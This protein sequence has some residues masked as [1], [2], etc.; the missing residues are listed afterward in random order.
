MKN[1]LIALALALSACGPPVNSAC[2]RGAL[3]ALAGGGPGEILDVCPGLPPALRGALQDQDVDVGA[4][5]TLWD[6][7]APL[8]AALE[9]PMQALD[10]D[11]RCDLRA[12]LPATDPLAF[13]FADGAPIAGVLLSRWLERE[14]YPSEDAKSVGAAVVGGLP[15]GARPIALAG[16]P[17]S[18]EVDHTLV[19]RA[20]GALEGTELQA[21]SGEVAVLASSGAPASSLAPVLTEA[22]GRIDSL[23]LIGQSEEGLARQ[24]RVVPGP[25][26]PGIGFAG[27]IEIH[28]HPDGNLLVHG[29]PLR[30]TEAVS[31]L[32]NRVDALLAEGVPGAGVRLVPHGVSM[33][34]V[35]QAADALAHIQGLVLAPGD[36]ACGPAPAGMVCVEGASLA[37]GTGHRVI[38]PFLIDVSRSSLAD[39]ESCVEAGSCRGT[40]R[41]GSG[42]QVLTDLS[43]GEALR[44]CVW[45]G[46]TLPTEW[47]WEQAAASGKLDDATE[48]PGEWTLSNQAHECGE[49]CLGIDPIGICGGAESCGSSMGRVVRGGAADARRAEPPT[50]QAFGVR[51]V[52]PFPQP[53]DVDVP[54]LQPLEP[55][56]E[57]LL[58]LFHGSPED[59]IELKPLCDGI[60]GQA[61][62]DCK[63]PVTYVIG[64]E[65]RAHLFMPHIAGLG[66][67]YVGVASDQNYSQAAIAQTR[68]LWLMDYDPKV[69]SVH[70]MNGVFIRA[71]ETP[72]AF[73][74]WY[75]PGRRREAQA[76][77][78]A[79]LGDDELTQLALRNLRV[80]GDRLHA[81]YSI[82]LAA[83]EGREG[84]DGKFV[85]AGPPDFGWLR[86]PAHYAHI[87]T[88]WQQGRVRAV[89]GDMLGSAGMQGIGK[90]ARE[91]GVPIRIYYTSNAPFAWGGMMTPE[92][93]RNVQA[94]PMDRHSLLVQTLGT[95]SGY[96]QTTYWHHS[97]VRGPVLQERLAHP[98][99]DHVS[100]VVYDRALGEDPDLTLVGLERK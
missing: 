30:K 33:D 95:R 52:R 74:E 21:L 45:G 22:H 71:S 81:H 100:K 64:N 69:V 38:S 75:R 7:D 42:P 99:F 41:R 72:E 70:R 84:I 83:P 53:A 8:E 31:D 40:P 46:K 43:W 12:A 76:K 98:G 23:A 25:A 59:P 67:G 15:E 20:D 97:L 50:S 2:D 35:L 66:G 61:H 5:A 51:C 80:W 13:A 1:V 58:A 34:R 24:V 3:D 19:L 11:Q 6:C 92:Y 96:G 36:A 44:F 90:A 55:P 86:N 57:A 87:R 17:L 39:Y 29:T 91:M 27:A 32:R 9:G 78:E 94:L 26:E 77:V 4:L 93:R 62:L 16:E 48:G 60:G 56:S 10:A 65:P 28:L 63:D 82:G 49:A 85:P 88:L 37:V 73:V 79:E 18:A 14:G 89:K 47:Q 68:W 54:A